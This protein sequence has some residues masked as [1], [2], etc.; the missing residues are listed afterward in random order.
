LKSGADPLFRPKTPASEGPTFFTP[1]S[2]AWHGLQWVT[3]NCCPA[4][5]SPAARHTDEPSES[6]AIAPSEF[7]R[8]VRVFDRRSVLFRMV[9][10]S[11]ANLV[12]TGRPSAV[13]CANG[14]PAA[15][16]P[17]AVKLILSHSNPYS[18]TQRAGCERDFTT[19]CSSQAVL[20][21]MLCRNGRASPKSA[22]GQSLT[23]C[24]K[25]RVSG[26]GPEGAID[27]A[28]FIGF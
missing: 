5:R 28:R 26:I 10:P 4:A 9:S 25:R 14:A 8:S 1:G 20:G 21:Q 6:V 3:K 23:N 12:E 18:P 15:S 19:Q 17:R 13:I 22:S 24:T 11:R 7:I 2:V 16:R 27:G